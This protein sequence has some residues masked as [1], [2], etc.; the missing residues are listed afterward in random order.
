M[1]KCNNIVTYLFQMCAIKCGNTLGFVNCPLIEGPS[2]DSKVDVLILFKIFVHKMLYT[3]VRYLYKKCST[4]VS[5]ICTSNV[6]HMCQIFVQEMLYIWVRYL[7]TKWFTYV[8]DICT[9][10]DVHLSQIFVHKMLYICVRYLYTK[11][12]TYVSDICT[13]NVVHMCQIFVPRIIEKKRNGV[14][15][16]DTRLVLYMHRK[17]PKRNRAFIAVIHLKVSVRPST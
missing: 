14:S 16:H 17:N 5:D 7:Y 4:Y 8:S 10:N 6:V 1:W 15:I 2:T 3:C 13:Q 12:G 9:R 11:C